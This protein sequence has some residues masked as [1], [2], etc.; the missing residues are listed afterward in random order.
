M[1]SYPN[2]NSA[3]ETIL[4]VE[5]D[6][7]LSDLLGRQALQPLGYRVSLASDVPSAIRLAVQGQPDVIL[8]NLNLPGLST[9]DFLVALAAQGLNTP[10]IVLAEKGQEQGVIQA[11]RLGAHDYLL[12]PARE[13]EVVAAVER[14]LAQQRE[15]R[16]REKLDGQLKQ[17]NAEL[18]RRVREL[19]TIFSIGRAVMSVTDQRVLFEKIVEAVVPAAEADLG[20]LTLRDEKSKAFLLAASRGLPEAWARKVGQTLDDGVSGLVAMS[21]ETL[22]IHGK[23]LEKFKVAVLGKSVMVVPIKVQ[24][25]AIGLLTVVRKIDNVFG[26]SEQTLLEAIADYASISLVN[27]RLFR[28]LAQTAETARAEE[29]RKSDQLGQ[30]QQELRSTLQV[31]GY[32]LELAVSDK[33]G[34]LTAQQKQAL[35]VVQAGIKHL[36]LLLKQHKI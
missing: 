3:A 26:Q 15:M 7:D 24:S 29:K 4:I 20:W 30:L 2:M 6:P 23:P 25:E 28:A 32:P 34:P 10:V 13:A 9:K 8:A 1:L 31:I 12:L 27:A 35:D 36:A 21:A 18:Q 11:F 19:T 17:A 22:E 16:A 14:A 33:M 5:N